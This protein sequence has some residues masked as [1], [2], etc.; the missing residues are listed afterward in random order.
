MAKAKKKNK[1]E[2]WKRQDDALP[3]GRVNRLSKC[4]QYVK[5][6]DEEDV[7]NASDSAENIS[8]VLEAQRDQRQKRL[9]KQKEAPPGSKRAIAYEKT[10]ECQRKRSKAYKDR[11]KAKFQDL[12]D[13]CASESKTR[14]ELLQKKSNEIAKWKRKANE[15]ASKLEKAL[16]FKENYKALL[17]AVREIAKSHAVCV[18][19]LR[20]KR[21]SEIQIEWTNKQVIQDLGGTVFFRGY[22]AKNN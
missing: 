9:K 14:A 11:Q 7:A 16:E 2:H 17:E 15:N 8:E 5:S 12:E 18:Q 20:T 19:N 6:I 21:V 3:Y 10:K 22:T 13:K 1:D 4:L